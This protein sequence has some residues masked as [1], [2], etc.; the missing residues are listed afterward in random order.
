MLG[1]GGW[2]KWRSWGGGG[3]GDGSET[4]ERSRTEGFVYGLYERRSSKCSNP[5]GNCPAPY[6][7]THTHTHSHTSQLCLSCRGTQTH[8]HAR[9]RTHI[10]ADGF[11]PLLVLCL[12]TRRA[13]WLT[14]RKAPNLREGGVDGLEG[15]RV[16]FL[17]GHFVAD[18]S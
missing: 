9:T 7:L 14:E 5:G 11:R 10:H 2:G 6:T 3:R 15:V 18:I 8:A 12:W 4:T 16:E 17:H 1:L 13:S